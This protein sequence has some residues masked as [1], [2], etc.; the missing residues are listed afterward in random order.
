MGEPSENRPSANF[1]HCDKSNG[2]D[3]MNDMDIEPG[4]V[5]CHKHH[6]GN[7]GARYGTMGNQPDIEHI[8]Q[9]FAPTANN[10][11]TFLWADPGQN[12]RGR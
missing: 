11:V 8:Q 3:T 7:L 5:I 9:A 12:Q 1:R 10:A 6:P 2:A 4:N